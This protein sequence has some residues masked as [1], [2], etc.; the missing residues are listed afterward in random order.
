MPLPPTAETGWENTPR[1]HSQ[2]PNSMGRKLYD[3]VSKAHSMS[4]GQ[5]RRIKIVLKGAIRKRRVL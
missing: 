3:D 1:S 2:I 4:G 5:G